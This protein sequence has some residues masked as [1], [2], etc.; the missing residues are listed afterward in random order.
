MRKTARALIRIP[1]LT[2]FNSWKLVPVRL[3][4][5]GVQDQ[6]G[7]LDNT[8]ARS[9]VI[10]CSMSLYI[11]PEMVVVMREGDSIYKHQQTLTS[12]VIAA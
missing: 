12:E 1:T 3:R 8:V 9:R 6:L 4:Q 7:H 5:L 2:F 11:S 10:K